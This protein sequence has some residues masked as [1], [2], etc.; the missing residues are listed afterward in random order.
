M[1]KFEICP[2]LG[3]HEVDGLHGLP[4]DGDA[5][6][7]WTYYEHRS[8]FHADIFIVVKELSVTLVEYHYSG[9]KHEKMRVRCKVSIILFEQH[10]LKM[11]LLIFFYL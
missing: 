8:N 5:Y 10:A 6:F 7:G 3:S 9:K 11:V 1:Q 2:A 4:G